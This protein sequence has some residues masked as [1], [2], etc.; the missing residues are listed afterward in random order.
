MAA[1]KKPMK[2]KPV[3]ESREIRAL[4][5]KVATATRMLFEMGLADFY[6]HAS[7]RIPGTDQIL[8]KPSVSPLGSIRGK[9]ILVVDMNNYRQGD[10]T[11][12]LMRQKGLPPGEVILHMAMYRKRPDVLGVVHTHQLLATTLGIAGKPITSGYAV[13]VKGG[14]S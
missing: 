13:L 5:E 4:K 1:K 3:R 10:M 8:I 2:R 11:D 12:P 6:G 7:A 14:I 9:D